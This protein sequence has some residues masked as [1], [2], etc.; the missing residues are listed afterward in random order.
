MYPVAP[1]EYVVFRDHL[2]LRAD[3]QMPVPATAPVMTNLPPHAE[4]KVGI[5]KR[6]QI[7]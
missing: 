3:P 6:C 1:D 5:R 4:L 2:K 7:R